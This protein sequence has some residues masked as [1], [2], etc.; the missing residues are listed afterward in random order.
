MKV[1]FT[2][3]LKKSMTS[4]V[5]G[6]GGKNGLAWVGRELPTTKEMGGHR[7]FCKANI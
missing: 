4:Q 1:L 2:P 7:F 6:I 5:S 3:A